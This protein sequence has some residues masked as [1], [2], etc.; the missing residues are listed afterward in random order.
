MDAGR[1]LD[2][3]SRLVRFDTTS[4]NS[5]LQLVDW[6]ED[7]LIGFGVRSERIY[8]PTGR[9]AKRVRVDRPR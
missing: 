7:Y 6:V 1:V 8:D 3:L 4:R 9:K 5:N 2:I